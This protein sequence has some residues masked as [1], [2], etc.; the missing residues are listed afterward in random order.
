MCF[1]KADDK[2][3]YKIFGESGVK[4]TADDFKK[5]FLGSIPISTE[6]RES[7]DNGQPITLAKPD[8]EISKIFQ[9]MSKKII[10]DLKI[11]F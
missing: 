5:D 9:L 7:A 3:E 1:F 8:N 4:Q 2:K 10:N 11:K 6:L